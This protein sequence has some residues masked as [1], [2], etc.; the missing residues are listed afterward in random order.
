MDPATIQDL[1]SYY[2]I[3]LVFP[4]MLALTSNGQPYPWA[5]Q[6]L[7]TFDATKNT[8][9]FTIR[10]GLKWSDG[11]PIDANTFAYSINRS[12]SP[13]TGSAV[14]Y[15]LFAIKDASA[16]S[17]QKCGADGTS[18]VGKIPTLIGDSLNVP[19]SQT[20]VITLTGP[21]PYF[22][23]AITYPTAD[24]QPK[25]LI[26]Q[27]GVKNW[28][29]HLTDNGGFGGNLY[30]LKVWDHKGNVDVIRND[31]FWGNKPQLREID[32]KVYQTVQAEYSDYLDGKLEWGTAPPAQYKV[33]KTRSDFHEE[34]GLQINYYQP[35]WNKAPFNDVRVRQAFDLALNKDVLANQVDEGSVI[36]SNHIVPAGMP[37]YFPGLVGPDGSPS[38]AGNTAKATQL[39]QS[40]ANDKCGGQIS[41]CTA[42]TLVDSNDPVI[43]TYDQAAVAMWQAAFPGLQIKTSFI[44]FNTLISLIYSPN[45]PQIFGIA[46]IA[47]Y[48]DPQDWL[49]LQFSPTALNNTGFV[50][51]PAA[52]ALMAKADADLD[53]TTR[54]QE[55]NQAEQSLQTQVAWIT[56]DQQKI[57]YN[58][59]SYVHNFV[60]SPQELIQLG[61]PGGTAGTGSTYENIYLSSH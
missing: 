9:T 22:L 40:Y 51:D 24:A 60:F 46:W 47:D 29:A 25:Q 10:P 31:G 35:D 1:Y 38:T 15:Y 4:S 12:L 20:L 58:V 21:A 53:P 61:G 49:S 56:E 13:C 41:K 54:F 30:K 34:G 36:P 44:D 33:S 19:D 14:T 52:N 5:A 39:M 50:N 16:Y 17:V 23:D 55:Y 18:V 32:F 11:T 27:Y 6:A 59:P 48:P 2:P 3:E 26:D 42:V 8:Y 45:V 7:P 43:V 28:T 37:G 57:F